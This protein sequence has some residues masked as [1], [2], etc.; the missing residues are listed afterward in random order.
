MDTLDKRFT[1]FD[2]NIPELRGA[3]P[4]VHDE[5]TF[6]ANC[7]QSYFWGDANTNVIQQ[8]SLGAG[9]IVTDFVDE[10]SGFVRTETGSLFAAG[11]KQRWI[12]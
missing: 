3:Q 10:L 8:K 6:H 7:D 9:I 2:G 12:F 4:L 11:D 1:M 5:S